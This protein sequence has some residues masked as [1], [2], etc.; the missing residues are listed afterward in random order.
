[1][2]FEFVFCQDGEA[3][4]NCLIQ[5]DLLLKNEQ[6]ANALRGAHGYYADADDY[7]HFMVLTQ[8]CDLVRRGA[9]PKANYIT[10]AAVRPFD[11]VVERLIARYRRIGSDFPLA[12]C[13]KDQEIFLTQILERFLHNT[14]SGYFFIR[15][16]SHKN[17]DKDLCV[18]LLLSVALRPHHYEAC[19]GAKIAQLDDIFQAKVGWLTGNLY[20][21]IGT[22]DLEEHEPNPS[23]YKADFYKEV[24][25][26]R[27]AWLTPAQLKLFKKRAKEWQNLHAG[28]AIDEGIAKELLEAI[29]NHADLVA[30]R[31]VDRLV[32][33]GFVDDQ[34]DLREKIKNTLVNDLTLKKMLRLD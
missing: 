3:D 29:P 9:K 5:G 13:A 30:D 32:Q 34:S 20:S 18:F 19:L 28:E 1:M 4:P 26:T 31:I 23:E 14:E 6:L 25:Y 7:T 12:I 16:D 2:A 22:P 8:S 17:V 27:S 10:L 15:K 21:R 33:S 11:I 24:L